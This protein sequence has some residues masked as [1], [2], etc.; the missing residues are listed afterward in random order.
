LF[1]GEGRFDDAQSHIEHANRKPLATNINWVVR[2]TRRLAC[3][4][5]KGVRRGKTRGI[6]R[7]RYFTKR[8]GAA[9][10]LGRCRRLL[11]RSRGTCDLRCICESLE[12]FY[13]PHVLTLHSQVRRTGFFQHLSILAHA[14]SPPVVFFV[15][16]TATFLFLPLHSCA[17]FYCGPFGRPS[18]S[19]LSCACYHTSLHLFWKSISH[20]LFKRSNFY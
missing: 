2:Q 20:P 18:P 11:R 16:A 9:I 13:L 7:H 6:A 10:D 5:D 15:I 3:G 14:L 1:L 12:S 17:S 8:L 19:T 4:I